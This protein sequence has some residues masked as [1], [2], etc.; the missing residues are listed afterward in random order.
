MNSGSIIG[1]L[2]IYLSNEIVLW[3]PT[4]DEFKV[5]PH[6][7]VV[8]FVPPYRD[9]LKHLHGFGYDSVNNDYKIIRLV[10]YIPM[11]EHSILHPGVKWEDIAWSRK[12]VCHK[13][14]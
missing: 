8:D 4:T 5:I 14:V 7:I 2:C 3:N 9:N 12:D 6:S 13:P 11:N 10:H 1:I